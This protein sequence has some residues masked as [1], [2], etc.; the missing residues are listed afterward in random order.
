MNVNSVL[1]SAA[2]VAGAFSSSKSKGKS[3]ANS[4]TFPIPNG[5]GNKKNKKK[6]KV[7]DDSDEEV[8]DPIYIA[9]VYRRHLIHVEDDFPLFGCSYFGQAVRSPD[10]YTDHFAVAKARWDAENNQA[11]RESHELGLLA[12]L[13]MLGKDAF[14]DSIMDFRMGPR[15]EVQAWADALEKKLIDDNGGVLQDMDNATLKQ[16]LNITK[17]GKGAK[18]W[19]AYLASRNKKF[20]NFKAEMEEYVKENGTA[21]VSFKYVN[22][23]TNCKLGL[24]LFNF[25]R[26]SFW[27]GNPEKTAII[28]WA[29]RLPEW[30]WDARK[31]DKYRNDIS[32][33][34]IAQWSN[35]EQRSKICIS[36]KRAHS[37]PEARLVHSQKATKQWQVEGSRKLRSQQM[38]NIRGNESEKAKSKRKANKKATDLAK[39]Q[40][41]LN[42]MSPTKRKH[43]EAK[44]A[45]NGRGNAQK[46]AN[47]AYLRSLGGKWANAKQPDVSRAHKEGVFKRRDK[48][49]KAASKPLAAQVDSDD[50]DSDDENVVG[51]SSS[52]PPPVRKQQPKPQPEQ[53]ALRRRTTTT[54]VEEEFDPPAKRS[55]VVSKSDDDSDDE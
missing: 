19:T 6:R 22:P 18:W 31:S 33:R 37:T 49:A 5:T 20:Q 54:T 32:N 40:A 7:D 17:G 16:T 55:K 25:R 52:A 3:N 43:E 51:S 13:D 14:D 1:M 28:K 46:K 2:S 38:E 27:A 45:K 47:L 15:S 23:K 36:I 35:M 24:A 30:H 10:K 48:A 8:V 9:V 42:G 12:V 26:G 29:E 53:G 41:R 11:T 4:N 44:I 34:K 39:Q 50:S 21:L